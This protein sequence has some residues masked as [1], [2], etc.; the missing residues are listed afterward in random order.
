MNI[1]RN[2]FC[3]VE[4]Q[5]EIIYLKRIAELF[6]NFPERVVKFNPVIGNADKLNRKKSLPDYDR[7]CFFD[8][9]F[10]QVEFER[11][12]NTCI[13]LDS[14]RKR[15]KNCPGYRTYHAYS[16][17]CFDLWLILHREQGY[18]TRLV[19]SAD[20]YIDDVKKIYSL[21]KD[22]DIKEEK[23]MEKIVSQISLD[24]VRTAIANAQRIR[25]SKLTS[26]KILT[27]ESNSYYPPPDFSIDMFLNTVLK[28][29]GLTGVGGT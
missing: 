2:Y 20:G 18:T 17:I 19:S 9:D 28:E 14:K 13:K 24:D 3:V 16:N 7:V 12:L 15:T 29:A 26:D 1:R 23:V 5:Q 10:N 22:A 21:G 27:D 8:H 6:T 4:G 11:N 25:K